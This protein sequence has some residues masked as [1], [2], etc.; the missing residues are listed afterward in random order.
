[1]AQD[2][3]MYCAATS[4]A[5]DTSSYCCDAVRS[6]TRSCVGNPRVG[7]EAATPKALLQW[8]DMKADA[9]VFFNPAQTVGS[10]PSLG[11]LLISFDAVMVVVRKRFASAA[12][13]SAVG[14]CTIQTELPLAVH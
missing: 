4:G 11:E 14:T 9:S 13:V 5:I 8:L 12:V 6:A 10:C 7:G 1:M 3:L 2:M